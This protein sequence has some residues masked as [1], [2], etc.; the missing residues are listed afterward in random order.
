MKSQTNEK[1]WMG[2][3]LAGRRLD[4][5]EPGCSI[6]VID[7]HAIDKQHVEVDVGFSAPPKRWIRLPRLRMWL[8]SRG[9]YRGIPEPPPGQIYDRVTIIYSDPADLAAR[10][11]AIWSIHSLILDH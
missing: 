6:W 4:P 1:R 2:E 3:F 5:T 11:H 9:I 8:P 10:F 7:I